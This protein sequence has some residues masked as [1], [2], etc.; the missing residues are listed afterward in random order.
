MSVLGVVPVLK[1][2]NGIPRLNMREL[3]D[4]PLFAHSLSTCKAASAVDQTLLVTDSREIEQIAVNYDTRILT[5]YDRADSIDIV[6]VLSTV[7]EN[8]CTHHEFIFCLPPKTPLVTKETVDRGI[9]LCRQKDA[10]RV[11]FVEH[12]NTACW[13]TASDPSIEALSLRDKETTETNGYYADTGVFAVRLDTFSADLDTEMNPVIQE[14]GTRE[15][16]SIETYG[17]WIQAE[18]HLSRKT[19]VYRL[20][21]NQDSGSGHVYRGITI[22]DKL[23]RHDIVFAVGA[24]EKLAIE[25]LEE[26]GYDYFVFDDNED[27]FRRIRSL[28]PNIVVNDM[29]NTE[30]EYMTKIKE[31][32]PR[33][34]NFEDLGSGS[35]HADAVINALYEYTNP[36]TN[37]YFGH[38]FF[39]LRNEF[40]YVEPIEEIETVDRIMISFGGVD[41]NNLTAKTLRVLSDLNRELHLDVVLGLGYTKRDTLDPILDSFPESMT[42]EVNQNIDSMAKSMAKADLLVTSNGRTVY[43][44]ASLNLPTISIAQNHREQRHPF[45]HVSKGIISLGLADYVSEKHILATIEEY[46]DEHERRQMMREALAEHNIESGIDRVKDLIIGRQ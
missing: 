19:L 33:I 1:S 27:F 21:G 10:D 41:E 6:D 18:N 22:A 26:T 28:N 3:G 36:P 5:I 32:V 30:P 13:D 11:V 31:I 38:E 29:L 45:A 25:K 43:E 4:E 39:C 15:A 24:N 20:R 40:R 44:A 2:P 16:T 7:C 8:Y 42:V 34:V 35:E 37:H 9:N 17:D 46:I 12:T 23:F 14:V